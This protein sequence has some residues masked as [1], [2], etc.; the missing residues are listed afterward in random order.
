MVPGS[1]MRAI[2]AD[3][4][5]RSSAAGVD[6]EQH[7]APVVLAGDQVADY[8]S[9]HV[10]SRVFPLLYDV[11]GRAAV[12]CDA[13]MAV[14]DADGKLLWVCGA[15]AAL[16]AADSINFVEGTEWTESSAGTNAPGMA[17]HLDAPASVHGQE[18][19]NRLVHSISCAAAP[20]HDPVSRRILGVVDITGGPAVATAQSLAMVHAAARM[21][22]AELGRLLA[23]GGGSLAGLSW[24]SPDASTFGY[25]ARVRVSAL[26]LPEAVIDVGGR[27]QRL[28]RRHSE[29][30]VALFGHPGGCTAEQLEVDVYPRGSGGSTLRVEL[31][32]LRAL[33]GED[34]LQS[35][36][37]RLAPEL[38]AD[39]LAVEAMLAAGRVSAALTAYQGPLL[40]GS[41]APVV[42]AARESLEAQ[43]RR[44][45]LASGQPELMAVWTRSRWGTDDLEMWQA[46]AA[47]LP[48][49]SPLRPIAQ[50]R[51]NIGVPRLR[52][53]PSTRTDSLKGRP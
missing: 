12:D 40:P 22:E 8:R 30:L 43:L 48:L 49:T 37:Y 25:P 32:R 53:E 17:I 11:L 26:G 20:I 15:P 24:G 6:P 29:L 42:L 21:A 35:R 28:S 47:T 19:F 3:S 34:V 45:V 23:V 13:V 36:P 50:Y 46:L 16:R 10:L 4:W 18:H 5:V 14:G 27:S 52:D 7:V 41:E 33:L 51:C 38:H 9:A 1:E 31:G 39:W 44:A 2:V